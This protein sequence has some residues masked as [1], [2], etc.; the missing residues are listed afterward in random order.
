VVISVGLTIVEFALEFVKIVDST[1]LSHKNI[2]GFED[3]T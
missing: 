1:H 2:E 3:Q